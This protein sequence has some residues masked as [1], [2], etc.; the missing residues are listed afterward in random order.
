M[1]ENLNLANDQRRGS[2][3]YRSTSKNTFRKVQLIKH[4]ILS[5]KAAPQNQNHNILIWKTLDPFE[6]S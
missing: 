6:K 2:D 1:L 5:Q 3:D 4:K